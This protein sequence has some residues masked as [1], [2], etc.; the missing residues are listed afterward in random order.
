M[1]VDEIRIMAQLKSGRSI[2]LQVAMKFINEALDDL[3]VDYNTACRKKD[4]KIQAEENKWVDLPQDCVGVVEC[5]Q[6]GYKYDHY[7][8]NE[9]LQIKFET[10]GTFDIAYLIKYPDVSTKTETPSI[11]NAYHQA[12]ALFVGAREK[13]RLFGEEDSDSNRLMMEYMTKAKK[14]HSK[15]STMKRTK[16]ISKAPFWG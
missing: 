10:E 16:K 7:V 1:T 5:T 11:N 3:A 8:I 9:H 4:Y 13:Q 14:A 6:D 12:I 15:L 2:D